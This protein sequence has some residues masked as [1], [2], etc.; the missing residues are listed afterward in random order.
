MNNDRIQHWLASASASKDPAVSEAH[1]IISY[2]AGPDGAIGI[3]DRAAWEMVTCECYSEGLDGHM[4]F[5]THPTEM[6]FSFDDEEAEINAQVSSALRYLAH[7]DLLI[8]HPD[9]ASWVRLQS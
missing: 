3:A 9:H 2:L 5:R 7:R 1:A 8:I 6:S 4:W